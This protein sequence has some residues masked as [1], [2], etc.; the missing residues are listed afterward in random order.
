M[1]AKSLGENLQPDYGWHIPNATSSRASMSSPCASG[2]S[3]V[4]WQFAATAIFPVVTAKTPLTLP[5]VGL[6]AIEGDALAIDVATVLGAEAGDKTPDVLL[7]FAN[8]AQRNR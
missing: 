8:A 5:Q 1:Q 2:T 4:R 3:S 6:A 7:A